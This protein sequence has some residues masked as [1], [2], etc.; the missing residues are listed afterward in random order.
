MYLF[1]GKTRLI[2]S[3]QGYQSTFIP[4]K[5][6]KNTFIPLKKGILKGILRG[7]S[8]SRGVFFYHGGK[9]HNF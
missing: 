9:K 4:L 7:P 8:A 6:M 5:G 3:P 1:S 2:G